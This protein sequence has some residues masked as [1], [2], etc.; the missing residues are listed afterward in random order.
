[1]WGR[2]CNA[3]AVIPVSSLSCCHC[4]HCSLR[5]L[6]QSLLMP[7][8][9][10]Q[11]GA[12]SGG[13]SI[14]GAILCLLSA[15]VDCE[16]VGGCLPDWGCFVLIVIPVLFLSCLRPHYHAFPPPRVWLLAPATHPMSRGSQG[17]GG[18]LVV[19]SLLFPSAPL[20]LSLAPSTLEHRGAVSCLSSAGGG[21]HMVGGAYLVGGAAC[22]SLSL[23]RCPSLAAI[24][25]HDPPCKQWLARLGLGAGSLVVVAL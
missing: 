2:G 19:I 25:T 16:V 23:S 24:S 8:S 13:V 10:L 4:C 7:V 20:I 9:T 22:S 5:S 17:W 3:A 6:S 12:H 15:G 1:M 14:G 21:C 18:C 11:A